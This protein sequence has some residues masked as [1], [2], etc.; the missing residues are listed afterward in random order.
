MTKVK[1]LLVILPVTLLLMVLSVAVLA[2]DEPSP[3]GSTHLCRIAKPVF[4]E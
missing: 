4:L 3:D 2:Q 1:V